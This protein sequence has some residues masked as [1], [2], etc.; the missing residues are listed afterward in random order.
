MLDEEERK[1]NNNSM[2]QLRSK[3]IGLSQKNYNKQ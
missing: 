1:Q 3:E 2:K